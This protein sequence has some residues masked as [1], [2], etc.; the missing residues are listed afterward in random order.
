M[1]VVHDGHSGYLGL[2]QTVWSLRTKSRS[3]KGHEL[4]RNV[5]SVVL[6]MR[7]D[8]NSSAVVCG[9]GNAVESANR[10]MVT[11]GQS[12]FSKSKGRDSL[13]PF[14]FVLWRR[15]TSSSARPS[16]PASS[17]PC[18][19]DEVR[20]ATSHPALPKLTSGVRRRRACLA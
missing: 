1:P 7:V 17:P 19:H 20:L 9:P 12:A 6:G 16:P 14:P 8:R 5:V 13:C 4:T 3:T 10:P 15:L 11:C 18:R 2:S